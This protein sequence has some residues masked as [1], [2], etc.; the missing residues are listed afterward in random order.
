MVVSLRAG[1]G[2]VG[3]A[4]ASA[5][6]LIG[7]AGSDVNMAS[8]TS[9]IASLIFGLNVFTFRGSSGGFVV[10]GGRGEANGGTCGRTTGF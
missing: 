6:G 8:R 10:S 9:K 4:Y 1:V 3:I 2:G 7:A 5:G